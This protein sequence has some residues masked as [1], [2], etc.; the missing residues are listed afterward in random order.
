MARWA[1]IDDDRRTTNQSFLTGSTAGNLD[2]KN[3]ETDG[4]IDKP[5]GK[6]ECDR[7]IA[8]FSAR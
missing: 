2:D 8:G 7:W 4:K 3:L 1:A 6:C 5:V